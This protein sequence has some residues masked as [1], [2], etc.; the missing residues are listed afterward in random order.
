[1]LAQGG[2]TPQTL[3]SWVAIGADGNVTVYTG[4]ADMGQGTYTVQYQL[5]AEELSVP[6]SRIRLVE[7]DTAMTPDQGTS[8]GSQC[9]PVNFNQENLA[10]AC[11]TAREA[12][13]AMAATKLGVSA[14][15]L[16][17]ADGV[18]THKVG[19]LEEG[20]LRRADWR[21]TLR[22]GDQEGCEAEARSELDGDGQVGSAR[23]HAGTR[24]GPLRACAERARPRDAARP[25]GAA[26][27]DRR[28]GR[29]RR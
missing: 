7:C 23:R 11:A 29:E 13:V 24:D 21:Q 5:A 25:H 19:R 22:H 1:M 14:S 3:D 2:N 26:A 8:S 6:I 18:V 9:H 17:V 10:Q 27:F 20:Q 4:R 28:D 16:T 15:D 12:L